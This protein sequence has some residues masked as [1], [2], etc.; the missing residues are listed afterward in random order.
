VAR[1]P[2]GGLSENS[3]L[4]CRN[5]YQLQKWEQQVR[6]F[7]L[8]IRQAIAASGQFHC[9]KCNAVQYYQQKYIVKQPILH[10]FLRRK[11]QVIDE[12]VECQ[13]CRQTYRLDVLQ[14]NRASL[15]DR[16]MLSIKYALESGISMDTLLEELIYAGMN[17]VGAAN[18]VSAASE[19]QQKFCPHCGVEQVGSLLRCKQCTLFNG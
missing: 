13:V 12:Y 15:A 19:C 1:P 4:Q 11:T 9:P 3:I 18:L 16:L 14:Y 17:A 2:P 8:R 7:G 5:G 10:F 6:I